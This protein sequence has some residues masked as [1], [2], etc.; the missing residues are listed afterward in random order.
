MITYQQVLASIVEALSGRPAGQKVLVVNHEAA[1]KKL[2]DYIQ[3]FVGA[4]AVA[5]PR[6]IHDNLPENQEVQI[7]WNPPFP[8]SSYAFTINAFSEE[9]TPAE[10]FLI[11]KNA[12][13]LTVKSLVNATVNAIAIPYS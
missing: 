8:D 13:F 5:P 10:L 4:I 9:G 7:F 11:E 1:E 12:E 3:Q 6:E 2:L